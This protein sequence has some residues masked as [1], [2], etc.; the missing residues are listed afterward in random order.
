MKSFRIKKSVLFIILLVIFL[1][2]KGQN[3]LRL[4]DSARE[5]IN[6]KLV[7]VKSKVYVYSEYIK[8]SFNDMLYVKRFIN[9]SREDNLDLQILRL[10]LIE[11]EQE[12]AENVRL[13]ELLELA[14]QEGVKYIISEVILLESVNAN[15][16]IYI[17]KG[18]N[19]GLDA[20]MPV[21]SQG[22]LIGRIVKADANY[23]EVMLLTSKKSNVSVLID[24]QETGILR[25]TGTDKL[26]VENYNGDVDGTEGKQLRITTSG[27]S[28]IFPKDI[29]IGTYNVVNPMVLKKTKE[30][31]TK[32]SFNVYNL[33]E[34]IVYKVDRD[35]LL[36]EEIKEQERAD[37][38]N[39]QNNN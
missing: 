31:S 33:R 27:I 35:R 14:P 36:H 23:S 18:T 1:I 29:Y 22:V 3:I 13:R 6:F 4:G 30:I 21:L 19:Q 8:S 12:K 26:I 9:K 38:Q 17:N 20:D 15:E 37:T 11:L 10:K 16:K 34:V 5:F 39:I 2:F 24:G 25:G 32:P 7:K 28:D